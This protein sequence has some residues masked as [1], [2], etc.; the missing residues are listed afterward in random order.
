M[1]KEPESVWNPSART[2]SENFRLFA[3]IKMH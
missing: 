3:D 2:V 1:G